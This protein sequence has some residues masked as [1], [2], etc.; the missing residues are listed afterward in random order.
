MRIE[1]SLNH[2]QRAG[3]AIADLWSAARIYKMSHEDILKRKKEILSTIAHC[4]QWVKEYVNGQDS[5]YFKMHY[6]H[7]EFCYLVEGVLYSTYKKS[8]RPTTEHFFSRDMGHVLSDAP[9]AH[10]YLDS[11]CKF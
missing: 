1:T 11:E 10:Y 6:Q 5:V 9:N 4:P 7:L 2:R 8:T 3:T